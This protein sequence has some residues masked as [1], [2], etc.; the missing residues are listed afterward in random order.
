MAYKCQVC[1]YI[2]I[3]EDNKKEQE[4]KKAFEKLPKEW[5]CPECGAKKKSFIWVDSL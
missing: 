2:Y 5:T 1:D 3:P 4:K